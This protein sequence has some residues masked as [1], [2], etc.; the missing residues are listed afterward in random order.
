MAHS[1]PAAPEQ[2]DAVFDALAAAPRRELLV[3]LASGEASVSELADHFDISRPA[4]S[5][6]LAVLRRAGLVERRR[7]GRR[8]L[9]R[10][11]SEPLEEVLD[12]L[13]SLDAFWASE[14]DAIGDRLAED[15][16]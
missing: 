4:V 2:A 10:L 7:E 12:W 5:K 3:L 11:D 13:V 16:G 15:E 9:Y 8:H 6:H 14:L 1:A